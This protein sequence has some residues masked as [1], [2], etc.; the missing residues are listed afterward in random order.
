MWIFAT[1]GEKGAF[2]L[3]VEDLGDREYRGFFILNTKIM[4][5]VIDDINEQLKIKITI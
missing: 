3:I 1:R 5:A 4:K 2:G